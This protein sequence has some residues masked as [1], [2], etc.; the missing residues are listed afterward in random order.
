MARP[1][2][3]NLAQNGKR[4]ADAKPEDVDTGTTAAI[5][6]GAVVYNASRAEDVEQKKAWP[7]PA[8]GEF[9]H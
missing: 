5:W 1:S 6:G 3:H 8:M 9:S 4:V 7:E 2:D